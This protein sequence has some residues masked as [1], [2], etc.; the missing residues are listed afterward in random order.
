[1]LDLH[2][3]PERSIGN[4]QWE[5]SLGMPVYQAVQI[6][7][8]QCRVIKSV[9]V[10]YNEKRPFESDL[11]LNLL[12]DGIKLMFD[13]VNQRL[14]IIEVWDLSKVKLKYCGA[15]FNSPQVAPTIQQIDQSFGATHPAQFDDKHHMGVL[16][17]RGI[18]FLFPV[19]EE[20]EANCGQTLRSLP[21]S[22]TPTVAKMSIYTG[23]NISE[24]R[25]PTMPLSC[26]H[27]N[28]YSEC[29]EVL[30]SNGLCD[31]LQMHLVSG[32]TEQD[33]DLQLQT[34]IHCVKFG[35]TVQD[36]LSEIGSPCQTFYKLEDKMRIH[37]SGPQKTNPSVNC[38]YFYNYFT[39]G[40][41]V[42]F[43]GYSHK[44]KKIILHTN[45]PGH[46]NFNIYYRSGFKI[47]MPQEK[48]TIK[49]TSKW[50]DVVNE[51]GEQ[52]VGEP[53]VLNRASSTNTTNPFG[54][55]NCYGIRNIIFEVMSND[56]IASVTL[57]QPKTKDTL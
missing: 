54:S 12:N 8:R 20:Y 56:Y 40:M 24:T 28:I 42:L 55:T 2:V 27:G 25:A 53:V 31:G 3:V 48:C 44:V 15:Y 14:R 36:V 29:T 57:Y 30:F 47:E 6:L 50:S 32:G 4:E 38:D 45:H 21:N 49:P 26:Y 51:C 9:E 19:E 10:N 39:L 16:S 22:P 52:A 34:L 23:N 43:D 13:P 37:S 11:V 17:F 46:Y 18:T 5:F 7:Q 1:M 33:R 41:D 35:H